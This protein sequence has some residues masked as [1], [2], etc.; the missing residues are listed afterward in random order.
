M[1]K[2]NKKQ[3]LEEDLG[4]SKSSVKRDIIELRSST[5]LIL[6]LKKAKQ[7]KLP[8]NDAILNAIEEY[9]RL[10]KKDAQRR[11]IQY[12]T[13]LIY[14]APEKDAIL[15]GLESEENVHITHKKKDIELQRWLAGIIEND[16]TIINEIYQSNS[17]IDRQSFQQLIRN[18]IKEDIKNKDLVIKDPQNASKKQDKQF[19]KL[20]KFLKQSLNNQV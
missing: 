19:K 12:M 11:H 15:L 9:S 8:L 3:E 5:E 17:E 7:N 20:K 18:A 1:A 4:P 16:Q 2:K 14:E 13:K 6:E 10:D